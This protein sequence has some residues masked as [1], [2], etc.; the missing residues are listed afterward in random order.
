MKK[1]NNQF[2]RFEDVE[3]FGASLGLSKIDIEL[4]RYKKELI[5]KLKDKRK[6]MR[7][8][9]A[10]LAKS[11]GSQ[12]PTIARMEAGL[13]G[14]ISLDFLAKIAMTLGVA[15]TIKGTSRAA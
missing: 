6:K 3:S 4:I 14:Q 12:Q 10:D 1:K 5:Q 2:I 13:I 8:S 7:L 9:Q 15:I 11:I